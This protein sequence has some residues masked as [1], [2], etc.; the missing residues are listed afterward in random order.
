LCGDRIA[1]REDVLYNLD[2]LFDQEFAMIG[3]WDDRHLPGRK[4]HEF[5]GDSAYRALV[6]HDGIL[7]SALLLGNREGDKRIR[8]LIANRERVEGKEKRVFDED[9][10]G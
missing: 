4:L 2:Y 10:S 6:T 8:K 5:P 3:L 9:F 1:W 7:K